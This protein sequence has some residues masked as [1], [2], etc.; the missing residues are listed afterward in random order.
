MKNKYQEALNKLRFA[1]SIAQDLPYKECNE[2]CDILYELVKKETPMKLNNIEEFIM[3][4]G[5]VYK[6]AKCPNCKGNNKV[7]EYVSGNRCYT[8]GQKL[9]WSD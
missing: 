9:D 3:F 5:T 1:V 8:C 7:R 2:L 6:I 4:D